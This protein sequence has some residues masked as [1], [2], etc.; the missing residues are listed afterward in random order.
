MVPPPPLCQ[1]NKNSSLPLPRSEEF[2]REEGLPRRLP[3]AVSSL[4]PS[5]AARS[6]GAASRFEATAVLASSQV[7]R[8]EQNQQQNQQQHQQ[9]HQQQQH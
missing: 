5:V 9:H 1:V 7:R 8:G 6:P 2:L 4:E 3:M